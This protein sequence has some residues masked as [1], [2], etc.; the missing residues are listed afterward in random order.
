MKRLISHWLVSYDF[1]FFRGNAADQTQNSDVGTCTVPSIFLCI[2]GGCLHFEEFLNLVTA[3][4]GTPLDFSTL[5]SGSLCTWSS[6][7]LILSSWASS[8]SIGFPRVGS[9]HPLSPV[10]QSTDKGIFSERKHFQKWFQSVWILLS[11]SVLNSSC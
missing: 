3:H 2:P 4:L 6:L 10:C 11:L 1:L 8:V 5:Y 9:G 7:T